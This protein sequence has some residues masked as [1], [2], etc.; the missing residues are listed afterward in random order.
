MHS[1]YYK[2]PLS[3]IGIIVFS[4]CNAFYPNHAFSQEWNN[5]KSYQKETGFTLLQEGCWIK[6]DRKQ[7]TLVWKQANLFNLSIENGNQKYQSISQIRDFYL[8]FDVERKKQG[9]EIKGVGIAAIAAKQ[10]SKLDSGIIGWGE[11]YRGHQWKVV[12][13]ICHIL[14]GK[15]IKSLSLQNLPFTFSR[16]YDGFECAIW[17]AYAKVHGLRVVDLLG[18]PVKE[19]VKIGKLEFKIIYNKKWLNNKIPNQILSGSYNY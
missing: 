2:N 17:D 5:L 16:E 10:L 19:K 6:G 3:V 8:W 14:L 11:L 4:L 18:G 7:Q 9:H 1:N 12:E 15:E 13:D